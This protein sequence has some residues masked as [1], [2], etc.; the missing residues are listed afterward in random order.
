ERYRER[1]RGREREG[2]REKERGRE[3]EGERERERDGV[4]P[5]GF[6]PTSCRFGF[7]EF[8]SQPRADDLAPV[9]KYS[10]LSTARQKQQ[11]SLFSLFSLSL[12]LSQ[13]R[14]DT[15]APVRKYSALSTARQKQQLSLFSLFSLSLSL[16]LSSL[17]SL[18]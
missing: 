7:P 18:F 4:Q 1:D 15:L 3:R 13:P 8:P 11:L 6:V 2:E 10:A 9:L 17:S 14:A 16:S 5:S 12:S